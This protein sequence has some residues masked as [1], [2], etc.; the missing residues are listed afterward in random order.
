M[1]SVRRIALAYFY[2]GTHRRNTIL[3]HEEKHVPAWGRDVRIIGERGSDRSSPLRDNVHLNQ[4]LIAIKG[5]RRCAWPQQMHP[6]D[7]A[8]LRRLDRDGLAI[9]TDV[10]R[11]GDRRPRPPEKI[12]RTENFDAQFFVK[13]VLPPFHCP[14]LVW[15]SARGD[16]APVGQQQR[17]GMVKS[18]HLCRCSKFPAVCC[19]VVDFGLEP[20]QNFAPCCR[21]ALAW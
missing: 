18:L 11:S 3:I 6:A 15:I 4:P 12:R 14:A 19:R 8:S 20:R 2:P 5:M 10:W 21:P 9:R 7:V 17:N 1:A 16:H 13:V